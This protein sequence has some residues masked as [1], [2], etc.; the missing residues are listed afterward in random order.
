MKTK[1]GVQRLVQTSKFCLVFIF[2]VTVSKIKMIF[3]LGKYSMS[4]KATS[5]HLKHCY[6][7]DDMFNESCCWVVRAGHRADL[8]KIRVIIDIIIPIILL[9]M[10]VRWADSIE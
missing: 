1:I 9:G 10:V 8:S 4:L 7:Q 6:F 3:I 2:I 5:F